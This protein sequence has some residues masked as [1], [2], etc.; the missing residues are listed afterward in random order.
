[1]Q[2]FNKFVAV[3]IFTIIG[4]A[5]LLIFSSPVQALM[6]NMSLDDLTQGSDA[7]V[8]GTVVEKTSGWN[9]THNM[10]CTSV[11]ISVEESLK[12]N[13]AAG[14]KAVITVPGGKVG[15]VT[16]RISDMPGFIVGERTLVFLNNLPA[17]KFNQASASQT[18]I[19]ANLYQVYGCYQGKFTIDNGMVEGMELD[20]FKGRISGIMAGTPLQQQ[21]DAVKN[22]S[23]TS[24]T[25]GKINTASGVRAAALTTISPSTASAGTDTE[26]TI[27]GTGFGATQGSSSV[28]FF[29]QTPYDGSGDRY[30]MQDAVHSWS[31]SQIRCT[32]PAHYAYSYDASASSGPVYV[33]IGGT[34]WSNPLPFTVTFSNG[35]VKWPGSSPVVTYK[36]NAST[37]TIAAVNSA[38]T[39]WNNAGSPFRFS[40]GGTTSATAMDVD[41]GINEILW[42]YNP[43]AGVLAWASVQDT[44]GVISECDI[45]FNLDYTWN[46]LPTCPGGQYD[47]EAIALHELG[48]WLCLNDLYGDKS[49]YPSD[50]SKVMFGR[51]ADGTTKRALTAEDIAGIRYIYGTITPPGAPP[52]SSPGPGANVPGTQVAFYW[53]APSGAGIDNYWLRVNTNSSFTGTDIVSAPVG[54][55][56][57]ATISGFSNTGATYYWY[58]LAHNVGGWGS[59]SS[60]RSFINGAAISLPGAPPLSSPGPGANVAGSAV[61]FSWTAPSGT[62][63]DN[64]W[65]RVNTNS[66][67]TGTDIYSGGVG[68]VGSARISGFS[69][70]G[71]TYYW[72]VLAHNAVGWGSASITSSIING[73]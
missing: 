57:S 31:N 35:K 36:V 6:I 70:T 12:G 21:P 59:V 13:I 9:S 11:T 3:S 60:V 41:N 64:Y 53:A 69:N 62:G 72:Y 27:T 71:A 44:A 68:Y 14:T 46:T 18:E 30:I 56:G 23:K 39:T 15:E 20:N 33:V 10:I 4:L 43:T 34:S 17:E 2:R 66:D 48:H 50:T 16:Q 19:A 38:A 49:G 45:E 51:T 28:Q 65:L 22:I 8:I 1:M 55:V 40:Y 73:P 32:V 47:V 54:Y 37:A 63:I 29:Y 61:T 24:E 5:L 58:V 25:S 67:F 52:L 42:N 7:I 26:V